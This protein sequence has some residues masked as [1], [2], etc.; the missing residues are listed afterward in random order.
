MRRRHL[1][2]RKQFM[3]VE[4]GYFTLRVKD[5]GRATR[6]YGALFGWE[7]DE[8]PKGAHVKNTKLP[9]GL[10]GGGP[11][12]ISFAYFQVD[13]ISAAMAQIVDLG[14]TVRERIE[15]PAGLM[16]VC[17]DDQDTLFSLWQAAPGF[18]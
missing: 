11:S 12:D 13:D 4:L 1:A 7:F 16:A 14:G 9:I 6:F 15:S 3:P 18:G 10:D 8:S 5:I 2:E 17:A